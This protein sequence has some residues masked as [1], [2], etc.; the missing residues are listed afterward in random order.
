MYL[1]IKNIDTIE[2]IK[3]SNVQI[4]EEKIT[5]TDLIKGQ[6]YLSTNC[7]ISGKSEDGRNFIIK[8]KN[9]GSI[10]YFYYEKPQW[11]YDTDRDDFPIYKCSECSEKF[12]FKSNYCP[13]CGKYMEIGDTYDNR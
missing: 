10:E 12:P 13:N 4:E 9:I 11:I 8:M 7:N 3:P 1:D 6:Y 5:V 2:I